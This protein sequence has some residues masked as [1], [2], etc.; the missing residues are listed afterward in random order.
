MWP[1]SCIPSYQRHGSNSPDLSG[2]EVQLLHAK[3]LCIPAPVARTTLVANKE[4]L[5]DDIEW[6]KWLERNDRYEE[7]DSRNRGKRA[8]H[9]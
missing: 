4:I 1:S 7:G 6:L 5:P 2:F 3:P 8:I 9:K